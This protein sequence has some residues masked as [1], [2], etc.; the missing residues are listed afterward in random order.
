MPTA[1]ATP[2]VNGYTGLLGQIKAPTSPTLTGTWDAKTGKF[3]LNAVLKQLQQSQ[4]QAN[5]GNVQ[6]YNDLLSSLNNLSSG[7]AGQGGLYSQ[8]MDQYNTLGQTDA[9]R[10]AQGVQQQQ[11]QAEQDLVSRGLGN[12]TIGENVAQQINLQGEQSLQAANEA[13]AK[14]KAGLLQNQA[15]AQTQIAG[16]NQQAIESLNQQAPNMQLYSEMI[17]QATQGQAAAQAQAQQQAAITQQGF[18]NY[19]Q[20]SGGGGSSGIGSSATSKTDKATNLGQGLTGGGT[21]GG[22]GSTYTPAGPMSGPDLQGATIGGYGISGTGSNAYTDFTNLANG[23][24]DQISGPAQ[25]AAIPTSDISGMSD[26]QIMNWA[27]VGQNGVAGS[28]GATSGVTAGT[29]NTSA[30]SPEPGAGASSGSQD[31]SEVAFRSFANRLLAQPEGSTA[32]YMGRTFRRGPNG[33][34]EQF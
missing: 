7:V 24:S 16:M 14:E 3:D 30:P 21:F 19:E 33:L 22:G 26:A 29:G 23:V 17:K 20:Q 12:T 18:K 15:G 25:G 32:V 13:I 6:R 31:N 28:Q 27:G 11:A 4:D 2:P 9:T 1:T 10:I 5:Q 8:A 34:S